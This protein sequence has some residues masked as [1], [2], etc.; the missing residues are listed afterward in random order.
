VKD[1][2]NV[3]VAFQKMEHA[4]SI[5]N[6][7]M[8][9]GFQ[10]IAV[11]NSGAQALACAEGLNSGIVVC[12]YQ[13]PDMLFEEL[14]DCL[15]R[16]FSMLLISSPDK[17]R[18]RVEKDIVCLAMPLKVHE[19]VSA[20][21]LMSQ[22]QTRQKRRKEQPPRPRSKEEQ[23]LIMEAKVLLMN[24]KYMTEEEAH[25]YIQKTSMNSGTDILETAQMVISLMN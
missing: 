3:I 24:R 25:R 7:L 23:A 2:T 17:W 16:E 21:E 9:S 8:R 15:P 19:L 20:L 10:V 18:D 5:K 6:I 12:G 11:C 14:Y 13:F 1:V 4:K 22:S